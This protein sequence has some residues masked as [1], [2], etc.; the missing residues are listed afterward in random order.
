MPRSP[1]L[2]ARDLFDRFVPRGA[3]LLS[4]LAFI[5]YFLGLV[6]ERTLSQTFGIG[7]TSSMPSR[8]P[9]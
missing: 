3:M 5:G 8:P 4:V 2:A 7:A 9:S 1:V 6:R